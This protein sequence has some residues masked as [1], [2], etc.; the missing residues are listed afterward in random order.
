[1]ITTAKPQHIITTALWLDNDNHKSWQLLFLLLE[2]ADVAGKL[3]QTKQQ[4]QTEQHRTRREAS[5][6]GT[7]VLTTTGPQEQNHDEEEGGRPQNKAHK[8]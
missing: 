3:S 2:M 4:S 6:C 8:A 7:T 5:C 1:M